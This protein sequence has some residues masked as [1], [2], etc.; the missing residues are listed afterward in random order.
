[1]ILMHAL[2]AAT[3]AER[4]EAIAILR[5]ARPLSVGLGEPLAVALR[6]FRERGE[7]SD[8]AWAIVERGTDSRQLKTEQDIATLLALVRRHGSIEYARKTALV[9]ARRARRLLRQLIDRPSVH[10]RF[11]QEVTDF[12]ITRN[13]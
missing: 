9:R 11:L 2:R 1:L 5:R 13:R 8:N 10:L 4:A 3:P 7:V 6:P 12:V